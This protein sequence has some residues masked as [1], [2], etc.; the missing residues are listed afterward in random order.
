[1]HHFEIRPNRFL[2]WWLVGSVLVYPLAVI[3]GAVALFVIGAVVSVVSSL[4]RV[5]MYRLESTVPLFSFLYG[6]ILVSALGA[7]IGFSL[8]HIQRH[9]LRRYLYW[10]ADYWRIL[11]TIGGIVGALL[12]VGAAFLL[13]P[14]R[15]S[16]QTVLLLLMVPFI[17]VVSL[18]QW[19]T[20][21]H[22][23]RYA[24]VWVLANVI[25][26]IVWSGVI[27][28]NQPD[29]YSRTYGLSMLLLGAL[30]VAA[31]GMIT[32][33]MMLWLFERYAYP[34]VDADG[35]GIPDAVDKDRKPSVW[36]NAI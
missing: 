32:G 23:T 22:A 11:S 12:V 7:A 24:G 35:N 16:N 31:Q 25:A 4:L 19:R 1:M 5:P 30:A 3:V 33:M 20:L 2:L 18:F 36:D 34:V 13:P 17:L 8:G 28:M 26:G 15:N 27:I 14:V 29:P 9:L 10:T 21:R 6:A